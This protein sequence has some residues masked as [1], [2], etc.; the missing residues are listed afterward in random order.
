MFKRMFKKFFKNDKVDKSMSPD[1][2]INKILG[3][4][5]ANIVKEYYDINRI[6]KNCEH[7]YI[8]KLDLYYCKKCN[9]FTII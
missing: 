2:F 1:A 9:N 7:E 3:N 6:S 4:D 8:L 5:V